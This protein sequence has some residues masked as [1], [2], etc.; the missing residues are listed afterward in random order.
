MKLQI[1]LDENVSLDVYH[2]LLSLGHDIVA[3]ATLP[4]RGMSDADVFKL[5]QDRKSFLITRDWHFT[6]SLRFPPT[7]VKGI[8]YLSDGNLKGSDEAALIEKFLQAHAA[9]I[10]TGQLV[11]ISPSGSRIR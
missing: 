8:L 6:N 10:F 2:R 4:E 5:A 11:F 1:L 7:Q 9:K 3:I